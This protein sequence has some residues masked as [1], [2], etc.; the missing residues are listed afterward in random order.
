MGMLD[1]EA[2]F[3]TAQAVTATG[4]TASSNVYDAGNAASS[5]IGLA[6]ELW[7]NVSVRDAATSGGAATLTPVLQ[8]SDDNSTF[9]DA[10]VGPT[11][12][13]AGL[14]AGAT[15]WQAPLPVGLK[16]Y[17]RVAFRV[18]TAALTGGTF[19]A[20]LSLDVQRN[21]ARPSGFTVA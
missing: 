19:D 1:K 5:D 2:K 8:H 18:A 12:A 3:A 13:L 9:S 15:L 10:Q 20:Y 16:R 4:D 6:R 7:L 14:T 17:T 11:V 21:I